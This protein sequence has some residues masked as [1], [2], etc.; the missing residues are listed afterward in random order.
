MVVLWVEHS[1]LFCSCDSHTGSTL[2][3]ELA[4]EEEEEEDDGEEEDGDAG[5]ASDKDSVA[6]SAQSAAAKD[7]DV[8][9]VG[10]LASLKRL[11][12]EIKDYMTEYLHDP[13]DAT[14]VPDLVP[15]A[16]RDS[17]QEE[18]LKKIVI[19]FLSCAVKCE[20]RE[21]FVKRILQMKKE[22][23]AA[24]MQEIEQVSS[25]FAAVFNFFVAH[26][27]STFVLQIQQRIQDRYR[28]F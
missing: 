7:Q 28:H 13:F 8:V 3:S 1:L 27:F 24:I 4:A 23:Q 18:E 17:G 5:D 15:I 2:S 19:L 12:A 16:K 6:S 10:R 26:C 22:A 14:L 25:L 11:L 9:W 21:T 20:R